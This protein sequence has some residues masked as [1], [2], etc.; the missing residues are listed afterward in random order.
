MKPALLLLPGALGSTAQLEPLADLLKDS[1]AIYTLNFAGHGGEPLA[2]AKFNL[3]HFAA[4][5]R[6]FVATLGSG[7]VHV[8]GYSMGGYAALLAA[9]E[10]PELFASISTLGTKFDWTSA[11]AAAET[12][13]LDPA[14]MMEKIPAFVEQLRQ[15]HAPTPWPEVVAAT[16]QL[17]RELGENPPLTSE[18]LA[19]IATPVLVLVGDAD[20][21]AGT[22]ASAT[23][24]SYL[25]QATFAVLE[26][27]PHPL[28]RVDLTA[29]ATRLR[30]FI[31]QQPTG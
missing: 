8:F 17:M 25:P 7:P 1:A 20:H 4:Q 24:A 6:E 15:R 13:F 16:A 27:T 21:T 12:R 26:Q 3:P 19:A 29:L 10:A 22:E 30:A 5:V 2:P 23:F 11:T 31:A 14:K 28:E 18:V 9:S